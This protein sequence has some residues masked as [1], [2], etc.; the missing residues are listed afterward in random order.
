MKSQDDFLIQLNNFDHESS[1]AA[2]YMYAEMAIQHAA[3]KSK[4]LLNRLNNTPTFWITCGASFQSSAYITIARIFDKGSKYNIDKLLDSMEQNLH[5][6]QRNALANRKRD[7]KTEDPDWLEN[8][9]KSAHFPKSNDVV[10]LR[11]MVKKYRDIYNRTIMLV[12]HNYLA[13]RGIV[14]QVEVQK[15]YASGKIRELWRLTTFLLQLNNLLWEQYHNG[16]K[17]VFRSLRHSVKSIYDAKHQ[18]SS[19]SESIVSDV[20]KLMQFIEFAKLDNQLK[21]TS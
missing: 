9:L 4:K 15:L 19:P 2:R 10:R 7:G 6:F 14:D 13:H 11:K 12:R 21:E 18:G 16:R 5:L 17:P 1:V 20:K 3:S 8:Y